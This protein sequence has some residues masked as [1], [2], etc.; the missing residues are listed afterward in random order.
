MF[1]FTNFINHDNEN[2]SNGVEGE[3]KDAK[4]QLGAYISTDSISIHNLTVTIMQ[5]RWILRAFE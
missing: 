3:I 5:A 4:M 2:D 1:K